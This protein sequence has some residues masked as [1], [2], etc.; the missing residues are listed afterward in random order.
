MCG[1]AGFNGDYSERIVEGYISSL[2]HRGPDAQSYRKIDDFVLIHTRLK[3]LDI[4]DGSN[5][6]IVSDKGV[7]IF[8]GEI[9]N[10]RELSKHYFHS[11]FASDTLFL[12]RFFDMY[13]MDRLDELE[14]MFAIAYYDCEKKTLHLARDRQ[15]EKNLYYSQSGGTIHFASEIRAI[16]KV[17]GNNDLRKTDILKWLRLGTTINDT[18]IPGIKLLPPGEMLTFT[19]GEM[20]IASYVTKASCSFDDVNY[21]DLDLLANIRRIVEKAVES[22]LMS[23]VPIALFLS[24]GI[25][26]SIVAYCASKASKSSI[27]SICLD[28]N[29]GGEGEIALKVAKEFGLIHENITVSAKDALKLLPEYL[30]SMDYP[31][32]DGLNS[33]MISNIAARHGFKVVLTGLGGDEWFLGY[34]RYKL[35]TK[36]EKL[37]KFVPIYLL[38]RIFSKVIKSNKVQLLGDM[39]SMNKEQ[40]F[41]ELRRIFSNTQLN[42]YFH[43]KSSSLLYKNLS[44]ENI[45]II[46]YFGYTVPILCRDG[47]QFGM[48]NSI[49]IRNPLLDSQLSTFVNSLS[50]VFRLKGKRSKQLLIDSF[51]D[52]LPKDVYERDKI[53]FS[54]PWEIWMRGEL[55]EEF[56]SQINSFSTTMGEPSIKRIWSDFLSGKLVFTHV[57]AVYTISKWIENNSIKIIHE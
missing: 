18:L 3:I 26:S 8:N 33:Y 22:R 25:D 54:F 56:E 57:L 30:K 39:F 37:N 40:K 31:T 19:N 16:L 49:E 1:I 17:L 20:Q 42:E 44:G 23:D 51:N 7:L 36:L 35:F 4:S 14:G 12:S 5:Q 43:G 48:A 53:G 50:I 9:Y 52:V 24:G 32:I 13:G 34:P 41:L 15:G 47:D 46:D 29:V 10:Y 38:C 45:N 55:A 28:F 27:R 11:E 6:P 21:Y 2:M